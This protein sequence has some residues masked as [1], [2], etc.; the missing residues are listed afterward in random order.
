M[1]FTY[2]DIRR[3]LQIANCCAARK[4]E[5]YI[6]GLQCGH[7]YL[8]YLYEARTMVN[9][10]DAIRGF[11]PSGELLSG[12]QA[13]VT[14]SA[15]PGDIGKYKLHRIIIKDADGAYV[16]DYQIS[17]FYDYDYN[18]S[19]QLAEYINTFYPQF[20]S[21]TAIDS[22]GDIIISGGDYD[23]INDY[24]VEYYCEEPDLRDSGTFSGGTIPVYKL[25]EDNCI[26]N[27]QV[28]SILERLDKLC[29]C[30]CSKVVNYQRDDENVLWDETE[31]FMLDSEDGNDILIAE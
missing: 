3:K 6:E 19:G 27:E 16:A 28:E 10:I 13:T 30:D 8:D 14:I 7:N 4:Y 29:N 15:W 26:T 2:S 9:F 20:Q 24:T 21:F 31:S 22:N 5:K 12:S 1:S 11:V 23:N 25:E 17:L 18:I